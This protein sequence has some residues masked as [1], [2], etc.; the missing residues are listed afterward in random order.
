MTLTD[1]ASTAAPVLGT[2]TTPL[3]LPQSVD[4][5]PIRS[6]PTTTTTT[7]TNTTTT[8]IEKARIHTIN[9]GGDARTDATEALSTPPASAQPGGISAVALSNQITPERHNSAAQVSSY[10]YV[11]IYVCMYIVYVCC[12]HQSLFYVHLLR[13]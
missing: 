6:V 3:K 12:T 10:V 7:T 8:A 9:K 4:S 1:T 2:G 5:T 11:C 13:I